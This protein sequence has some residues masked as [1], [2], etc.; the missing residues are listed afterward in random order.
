MRAVAL[1][2][3]LLV[4]AALPAAA[5][6]RTSS[7]VVLVDTGTVVSD[8][9]YA[10]GNRVVILGQVDGDLVVSAFE[11]VV[12]AGR[13][14]GDVIG[15][16]G[17]IEI[18]GSV[19]GSVRVLAST[20]V[21]GGTVGKDVVIAAWSSTLT[22]DVGGDALVWGNRS[23]LSGVVGGDIEGQTRRMELGGR[24]DGRV[25]ITVGELLIAP[26]TVVVGDLAYRSGSVAVGE[27]TADVGGAVV[28][29]RP[30]APNVRVRALAV[31]GKVVLGLLAAVAGL[32]MMWAVPASSD[33]ALAAVGAS[34]WRAWL[35]GLAVLLSPLVVV[36][37]AAVLL[38]LSPAEASVPVLA[39]FV[40]FFFAVVGV[41]AAL[42][43][44]AP[45]AV[46]PWL[47]RLGNS[48]RSVVRSF[49]YAVP[50]VTVL[51]LLPWV[52][53]VV[54]LVVVPSGIGGWLSSSAEPVEETAVV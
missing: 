3:F 22:G 35:R 49:L 24:V 11:D 43:F 54:A 12:V 29:R 46:Y 53:W 16:A 45:V 33:R 41:V 4:G 44:V 52:V 36:A 27:S 31:M 18:S 1:L 30:I 28:H 14:N 42:S 34:W 13:V 47:G 48:G 6:E 38:R 51:T 2:L 21:V 8:D 20:V 37:V 9:L 25:E 26:D 19:E 15:A 7:D 5:A 32:L 39:V 40:P 50:I 10:A 23:N 17:S